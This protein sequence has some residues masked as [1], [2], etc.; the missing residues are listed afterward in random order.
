MNPFKFIGK[1]LGA[2]QTRDQDSV[3]RGW[4][5]AE[6][7]QDDI[8]IDESVARLLNE[9]G[10]YPK[11][12]LDYALSAYPWSRNG[13]L[14]DALR[15]DEL[16]GIC[17]NQDHIRRKLFLSARKNG[18]VDEQPDLENDEQFGM[19][20]CALLEKD[21][22]RNAFFLELQRQR[23]RS[24]NT[25]DY[26]LFE[27]FEKNPNS[28]DLQKLF[29]KLLDDFLG[30]SWTTEND[31]GLRLCVA[32]C[33]DEKDFR[34]FIKFIFELMY[35]VMS[36]IRNPSRQGRNR[37]SMV[38]GASVDFRKKLNNFLLQRF[39][40]NVTKKCDGQRERQF[41]VVGCC[42]C[43]MVMGFDSKAL[44]KKLLESD[45]KNLSLIVP[46]LVELDKFVAKTQRTRSPK[47]C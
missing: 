38:K 29:F 12:I 26:R 34:N 2:N 36:G 24:S 46:S 5:A 1:L 35:E 32:S 47:G 21:T 10:T 33:E 30:N 22:A 15:D 14:C 40:E 44:V 17:L 18:L 45:P 8:T 41:N 4:V 20:A 25:I 27:E 6:R 39:E 31:L 23:K 7:D 13:E 43:A 9:D 42:G 16:W 3:T 37:K 19:I 11:F 28:V